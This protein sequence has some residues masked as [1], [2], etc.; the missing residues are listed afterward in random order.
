MMLKTIPMPDKMA[1]LLARLDAGER[2]LF[3]GAYTDLKSAEDI[4]RLFDT[5]EGDPA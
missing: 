1:Y 5:C 4:D 3:E 2:Q